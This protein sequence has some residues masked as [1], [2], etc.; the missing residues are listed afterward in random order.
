MLQSSVVQP[1]T[2]CYTLISLIPKRNVAL[3]CVS[4]N[5]QMIQSNVV[6]PI[7]LVTM[8]RKI[9]EYWMVKS[10]KLHSQSIKEF[11]I[12]QDGSKKVKSW[13]RHWGRFLYSLIFS[14]NDG[15]V[16][17]FKT[18]WWWFWMNVIDISIVQMTGYWK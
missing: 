12:G 14:K 15:F 9:P 3:Q 5:D 1:Y 16:K 8:Y 18:F 2:K 6:P 4:T 7:L 13:D 10:K 11:S 17:T